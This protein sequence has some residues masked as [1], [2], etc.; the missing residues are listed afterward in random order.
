MT[1]HISTPLDSLYSQLFLHS[2]PFVRHNTSAR[3]DIKMR[4]SCV[5]F[6]LA[7]GLTSTVL[8]QNEVPPQL[9]RY[10]TAEA[11]R[12]V[13]HIE[14]AHTK[15]RESKDSCSRD[16]SSKVCIG[17][18]AAKANGEDL[19]PKRHQ[20]VAERSCS[21]G[22][23]MNANGGSRCKLQAKNTSVTRVVF[24]RQLP[25]RSVLYYRRRRYAEALS[26]LRWQ[27]LLDRKEYLGRIAQKR[28]HGYELKAGNYRIEQ[29]R[30][31]VD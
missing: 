1:C 19:A 5:L 10:P 18:S 22:K 15:T 26:E 6:A 31:F 4:F 28:G 7:L 13:Q 3:P 9:P 30:M 27:A 25:A 8:A 11:T 14:Y 21:H 29:G 12:Q 23:N 16:Q 2:C 24:R 17:R 20:Q